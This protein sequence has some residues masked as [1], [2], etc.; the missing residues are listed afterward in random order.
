MKFTPAEE[1]SYEH[2]L[3]L[4]LAQSSQ[5]VLLL[6]RGGGLE[7]KLDFEA[8]LLTFGPVLPFSGGDEKAVCV[9]NPCSF[10]IEF[11][12]LEFDKVYLEEE[13][14]LRQMSGYDENNTLLLPPR[15]PGEKLPNVS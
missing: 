1:S 2:R 4:R 8:H 13:K 10:P 15:Q 6:C 12:S 7:P 9:R 3:A 11:Y 5:R 14:I